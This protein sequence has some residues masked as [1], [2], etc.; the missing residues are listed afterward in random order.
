VRLI[1]ETRKL[2][3][4]VPAIT[5]SSLLACLIL[6]LAFIWGGTFLVT[7]IRATEMPPFWIARHPCGLAATVM[8]RSG[9]YAGFP[10]VLQRADPRR[11]SPR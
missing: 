11:T 8:T 9:A 4:S 2:H 3:V 1:V 6:L 7:E 10:P 5:K